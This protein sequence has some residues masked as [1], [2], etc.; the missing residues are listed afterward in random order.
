MKFSTYAFV[1]IPVR[2]AMYLSKR[3]QSFSGAPWFEA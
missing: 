1:S 2:R 3:A